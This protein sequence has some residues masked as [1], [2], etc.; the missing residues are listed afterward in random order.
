M[1]PEVRGAALGLEGL[2]LAYG[3]NVAVSNIALDVRAGEFVTLLG[4]SGSGK[5]TTLNLIAGFLAPDAGRITLDGEAVEK[6]PPNRRNIGMVFQNYALFPHMTAFENVAFPLRRRRVAKAEVAAR[7]GAALDLVHLRKFANQYPSQ[8][9]GG[10][11]QRIAFA[12]AV[13]YEPRLLLMD[14][15]LGALDRRLRETLQGEIRH[16]YERLGITFV[17]VTHDQ[18]EALAL[19]ERIAVF[20]EGHI[21]QLGTPSEV[22]ER[23]AT[24]FVA[25]FLGDS[26]TF[27]GEVAR[28]GV[29]ATVSCEVGSLRVSNPG[30][31]RVGEDCVIMVRPEHIRIRAARATAP[32]DDPP[33]DN[34]VNGTV[35]EVT[36]FGATERF[37]IA[38]TEGLRATVTRRVKQGLP[39]RRGDAVRLSW[40][41]EDAVLLGAESTVHRGLVS[42]ASG[43]GVIE[44]DTQAEVAGSVEPHSQGVA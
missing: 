30:G 29:A 22:Y 7:V 4:P 44:R 25:N 17:Y 28:D 41:P 6:L 12:R 35:V 33:D 11:Q 3:E 5:T 2:T 14:E 38:L 34:I 20:N 16:L 13:V 18:D 24:L 26:T 15:P 31:M 37:E 8:L 21:E 36:Y 39:L 23:P 10:Q 9:S 27:P 19:S 43:P 32:E 1:Q 42:P 40:R